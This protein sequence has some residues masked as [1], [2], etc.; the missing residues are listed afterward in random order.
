MKSTYA[1][2]RKAQKIGQEAED[3]EAGDHEATGAPLPGE[4]PLNNQET[5]RA[6][7]RRPTLAARGPSKSTRKSSALRL[8]FGAG[9]AGS[10]EAADDGSA[11]FVPTKSRLSRQAIERKA[12]RKTLTHAISSSPRLVRDRTDEGRPSYDRD[13]LREL[14]SAT[15]STPQE[16][17]PSSEPD[18]DPLGVIAKFGIG[19]DLA[20]APPLGTSI[21]PSEAE[22][23]EKKERRS[24]L[25]R[26]KDYIDLGGGDADADAGRDWEDGDG[27]DNGDGDGDR[28]HYEIAHRPPP[29]QKW[30]ETRLVRDD[31]DMAEG[32]DDFVNDDG[33]VT[34]GKKAARAQAR[35]KRAAIRELIAEAEGEDD[36]DDDDGDGDGVAD[37]SDAEQRAAYDA[38]QTRAGTTI[39]I[40]TSTHAGAR[41]APAPLPPRARTPPRISPLPTLAACLDRLQT[42]LRAMQARTAQKSRRLQEIG[43]E[44]AEIAIREVEIQQLLKEAAEK[45][46]ALR[47]A[48]A[49][50]LQTGGAPPAAAAY[51]APAAEQRDLALRGYH[52]RGLEDIGRMSPG[53]GPVDGWESG[54][55][56]GGGM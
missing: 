55:G 14:R 49:A 47:T 38:A 45:Y 6:V 37:Q 50:P 25:A 48:A 56:M 34:L 22:I 21:I 30:A 13:H 7:F 4:P 53:L 23:R 8:S 42:T 10:E 28:D 44:K 52:G 41:G 33:Q 11:V 46:D 19:P 12:M 24:R 43:R 17:G 54:G 18:D 32:F 15:P 31:E 16:A 20:A 39:A 51:G 9:E 5:A 27:V 3:L 1:S 40:S 2:R 29:A 26:E 35:R 36:D